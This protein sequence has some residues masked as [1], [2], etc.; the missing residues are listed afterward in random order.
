MG[1]F[2][3]GPPIWHDH[4]WDKAFYYSEF[5]KKARKLAKDK[6]AEDKKKGEGHDDHGN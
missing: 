2:P 5:N 6:K 1:P 4:G 3:G